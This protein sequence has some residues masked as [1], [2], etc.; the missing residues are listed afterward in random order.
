M[1]NLSLTD[2]EAAAIRFL[3]AEGLGCMGGELPL[4]LLEDNMA[5]AFPA[6]IAKALKI[7]KQAVGGVMS[8]LQQKGLTKWDEI[9]DGR[10]GYWLTN[11]GIR[12]ADA[13]TTTLEPVAEEK[14]PAPSLSALLTC[15]KPATFSVRVFSAA[16]DLGTY[17]VAGDDRAHALKCVREA[18]K[19]AG[20]SRKV[21]TLQFRVTKA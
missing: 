12:F 3:V 10:D 7:T 20:I 18:V 15:T 5:C 9:S 14:A 11:D 17:P 1:T 6:E 13:M 16:G 8:S 19:I 21:G 2:L 4:D